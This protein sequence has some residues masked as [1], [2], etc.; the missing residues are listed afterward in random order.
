MYLRK[1]ALFPITVLVFLSLFELAVCGDDA[2]QHET[3]IDR[4][5]DRR[6]KPRSPARA[7][8]WIPPECDHVR[9]TIIGQMTLLEERL[10]KDP[11]IR[12]TAA[13]QSLAI[14]FVNPSFDSLFNYV[15]QKADHK[16]EKIL[17]DLDQKSGHAELEY[18]P[19]LTIGHSTGG[20]F[21]R[22]VAYWK[23]DRVIGIIHIKSG[24]LHQHIY[25]RN[26][27]LASVPFLAINGQF[28]EYGPEGG[29][30][31]EYGLETQWIMLLEQLLERRRQDPNNLM[32]ML[33]HPAGD[34]I[35]WDDDLSRYCALFIRKAVEYRLPKDGKGTGKLVKCL[36]IR[37]EDGWLSDSDIKNP[38][39][40]PAPYAEY[41]GDK[42]RALWHFDR[43]IAEA[44]YT[45]HQGRVEVPVR[46]TPGKIVIVGDSITQAEGVIPE[47]SFAKKLEAKSN[48]ISVIAQGRGGW[49]TTSY[50]SQ[51]GK[52]LHDLPKDVA[53][54]VIQL[55]SN[56]LRMHGHSPEC[57]EQTTTNM[58]KLAD[59]YQ[60]TVPRAKI[61]LAAPPNMFP[62]DL[63]ER[64]VKAG[65]GSNSPQYLKMLSDSYRQLAEREGFGFIDLYPVVSPGNTIDGAHPNTAGH[66]QIA[67]AVWRV[68][69]DDLLR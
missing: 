37:A 25:G 67:E 8:L 29:I 31:L 27:S 40:K 65:F 69:A 55:G 1:S 50:L 7:F 10:T 34:H 44:T 4:G 5:P 35:S 39:H 47:Q 52:V 46:V 60:R 24:N 59:L 32:S 9:G 11:I 64:L 30:R 36:P 57:I 26:R 66:S 21:A 2:W 6:G 33:V 58:G 63:T 3:S 61:Y 49:A 53:I 19:M 28:E 38:Q 68:L 18:A 51:I 13:A 12:A 22:N 62:E 42:N 48:S 43:E 56:D 20:I 14:I 45:Y 15:E 23:P 41:T 16:L 54:V 17:S